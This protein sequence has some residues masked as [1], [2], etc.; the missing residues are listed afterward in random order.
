LDNA[1]AHGAMKREATVQILCEV[2]PEEGCL[3]LEVKN[4]V[5]ASVDRRAT[6]RK[7][8]KLRESIELRNFGKSARK[9]GGSG[10]LK[11]AA[12]LQ[13]SA[14]GSVEFGFTNKREFRL[15]LKLKPAQYTL[16]VIKA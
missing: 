12:A 6:E 3:H 9:E 7:L 5:G 2:E 11:I 16:T 4:P 13:H 1:K 8:A 15:A 14:Y 10:F